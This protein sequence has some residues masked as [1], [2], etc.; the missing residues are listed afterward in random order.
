MLKYFY[1]DSRFKSSCSRSIVEH[2]NEESKRG[3]SMSILNI[4]KDVKLVAIEMHNPT[5]N[6]IVSSEKR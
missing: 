2:M 6:R 4:L 1:Q 5:G 3:Q